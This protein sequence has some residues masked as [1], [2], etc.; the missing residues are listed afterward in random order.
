[1]ITR[2]NSRSIDD[3]TELVVEIR[4]HAPGEKVEIAYTRANQDG[5]A[6]VVLGDDS[7]S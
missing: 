4:N 5:T 1:V 3:D 2:V 6:V 7:T